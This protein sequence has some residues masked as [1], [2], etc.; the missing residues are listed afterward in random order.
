MYR[1]RLD[2]VNVTFTMVVGQRCV[3]LLLWRKLGCVCRFCLAHSY[4]LMSMSYVFGNLALPVC[5]E[6]RLDFK[7]AH[8]LNNVMTQMVIMLARGRIST[9]RWP[10]KYAASIH[11]QCSRFKVTLCIF[12]KHIICNKKLQCPCRSFVAVVALKLAKHPY[13]KDLFHYIM[14]TTKV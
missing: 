1:N 2:N 12:F 13:E 9:Y 5:E 14:I 3:Q 6:N 8:S 10:I 7:N 4:A 11:P